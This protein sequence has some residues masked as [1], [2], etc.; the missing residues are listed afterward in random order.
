M[1]VSA[2]D[3]VPSLNRQFSAIAKFSNDLNSGRAEYN[4]PNDSLVYSFLSSR[5]VANRPRFQTFGRYFLCSRSGM[6]FRS[7]VRFRVRGESIVENTIDSHRRVSQRPQFRTSE[8]QKWTTIAKRGCD[9]TSGGG[10][11]KL[12]HAG[13]DRSSEDLA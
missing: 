5:K 8:E 4:D 11:G 1:S 12:W 6:R 7:R 3:A 10:L 2:S 9:R 13:K